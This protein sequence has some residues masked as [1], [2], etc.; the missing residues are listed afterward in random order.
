L[1][2]GLLVILLLK[3]VIVAKGKVLEMQ[4]DKNCDDNFFVAVGS[5]GNWKE[6]LIHLF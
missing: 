3:R 6:I 1:S 4:W 2:I 5:D